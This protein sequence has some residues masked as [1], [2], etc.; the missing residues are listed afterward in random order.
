MIG[1][2]GAILAN[3]IPSMGS[4]VPGVTEEEKN[5]TRR[6]EEGVER[7]QR[8]QGL[9][10]RLGALGIQEQAE[11]GMQSFDPRMAAIMGP[12]G[13][14]GTRR[15]GQLGGIAGVKGEAEGMMR[16]EA[17]DPERKREVMRQRMMAAAATAAA[18]G[19]TKEQMFQTLSGMAAGDPELLKEAR[20]IAGAQGRMAQAGTIPGYVEDIGSLLG[21]G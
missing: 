7:A 20:N 3:V 14:A 1:G 5:R 9:Y 15:L 18:A 21:I 8:L 6:Y 11:A 10:R 16:A 4:Q 13:L 19:Q 12:A 17:I 2:M